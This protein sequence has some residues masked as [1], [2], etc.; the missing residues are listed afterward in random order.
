MKKVKTNQKGHSLSFLGKS[1][2]GFLCSLQATIIHTKGQDTDGPLRP[3]FQHELDYQNCLPSSVVSIRSKQFILR[4]NNTQEQIL[5]VSSLVNYQNSET[6]SFETEGTNSERML[7]HTYLTFLT[8][9]PTGIYL[10]TLQDNWFNMNYKEY[11][12]TSIMSQ[13]FDPGNFSRI[14]VARTSANSPRI[15]FVDSNLNLTVLE[16]RLNTTATKQTSTGKEK[17]KEQEGPSLNFSYSVN[18]I[19]SINLERLD[20][21]AKDEKN[22]VRSLAKIPESDTFLVSADRFEI[23]KVDLRMAP[24][25]NVK[26]VTRF[27]NPL[28]WIRF[29]VCAHKVYRFRGQRFPLFVATSLLDNMNVVMDYTTMKPLR[30]FS[31]ALIQGE[32]LKQ[33]KNQKNYKI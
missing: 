19:T 8:V 30:F 14:T 31:L 5:S 28:D 15:I 12:T 6:A 17:E 11:S 3:C 25:G 7:Y 1:L 20:Q 24:R 21:R 22:I 10:K 26:R 23:L 9:L 2:L 32:K 16:M 27:T 29:I 13:V 18:K 33:S 4:P